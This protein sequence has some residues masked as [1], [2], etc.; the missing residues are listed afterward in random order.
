MGL[1]REIKSLVFIAVF[2]FFLLKY[3]FP[4]LG[5]VLGFVSKLFQYLA[6]ALPH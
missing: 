1:I 3:V 4:M 2:L 5:S 6:N